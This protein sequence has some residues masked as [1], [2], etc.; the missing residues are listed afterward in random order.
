MTGGGPNAD[1]IA[2]RNVVRELA[3]IGLGAMGLPMATRLGSG[4]FRVRGFDPSVQ[5][6][7]AAQSA[8]ITPARTPAGAARNADLVLLAVRDHAQADE[9][10]FGPHGAVASMSAGTTVL[11][12]STIGAGEAVAL[13]ARLTQADLVTVDAPVS[14][15]PARAAGGDLLIVVGASADSLAPAWP[16]LSRLAST[17]KVVGPRVGDGQLLKVI[18]QL[19]AGVHI[20]AAAEAIAL[21]RAVGLDPAVVV[22]VLAVG[23]GSSFMLQD[24]GPRMLEALTTDPDVRS[25]ID[26]FVK[27]MGLVTGLARSAHLAVPVAAAAQQLYLLAEQAGLGSADDSSIIKLLA[28]HLI[29][30]SPP[31][32]G[33]NTTS[34]EGHPPR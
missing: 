17:L 31:Q 5:R 18:N 23:A 8:G 28:P 32:A 21:A 6:R 10:L 24:R 16:V 26:I 11:L 7:Q 3:V 22:D 34:E 15:G 4:G 27:D 9:A 33:A 2:P 29:A 14:G 30:Q 12:T 25:R 13:A 19:L 1:S 20:V